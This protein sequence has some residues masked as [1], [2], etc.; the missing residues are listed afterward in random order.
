MKSLSIG[1]REAK[2]QLS[3]LVSEA[4]HG[5]VWIL[6]DRGR[7]VARLGPLHDVESPLGQRI[8]RLENWGW[9]GPAGDQ[10]RAIPPPVRI[11]A[12]AQQ[13]LQEDRDA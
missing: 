6:T 8:S 11:G 5:T 13:A 12:D 1:I 4:E 3:R 7:A 9:I 2:A 10:G